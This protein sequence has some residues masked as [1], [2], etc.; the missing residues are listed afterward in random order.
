MTSRI[1]L[2]LAFILPWPA[3]SQEFIA[4]RTL[5]V[6]TLIA[7]S[8][9]LPSDPESHA[10]SDASE[11]IGQA[12][13]V[14]IYE[15]RPV[16]ANLLRPPLLVT[17]NQI[18]RLKFQSGSLQIAT[19]GRALNQG[20][21]GDLIRVMNLNSHSTVTARIEADGTVQAAILP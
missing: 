21:E 4:A 19:L 16:R 9:L 17:R 12:T 1:F 11:L 8:D 18:V 15:G 6:G 13:R 20:A 5:S 10:M 14:T 3:M 7:A 2:I